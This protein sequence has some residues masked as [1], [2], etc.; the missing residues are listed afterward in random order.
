M[1]L[2]KVGKARKVY[3]V[4]HDEVEFIFFSLKNIFIFFSIFM[5]KNDYFYLNLTD[6]FVGS[7]TYESEQ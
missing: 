5:E 2:W 3:Q 4:S 7:G 6:S 1:K